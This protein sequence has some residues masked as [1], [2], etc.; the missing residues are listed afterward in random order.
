MDNGSRLLLIQE[1]V[2]FNNQFQQAG[3]GIF[4]TI[5]TSALFPTMHLTSIATAPLDRALA[6]TLARTITRTLTLNPA[7]IT[8]LLHDTFLP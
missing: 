1:M 6:L 8:A 4:H 7:R 3:S 2:I 5:N